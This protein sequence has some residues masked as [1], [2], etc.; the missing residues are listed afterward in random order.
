MIV[1]SKQFSARRRC[2]TLFARLLTL[3]LAVAPP[4]SAG[5]MASLLHNPFPIHSVLSG[6]C[7]G[8]R[9]AAL[10]LEQLSSALSS[11]TSAIGPLYGSLLARRCQLCFTLTMIS[12]PAIGKAFCTRHLRHIVHRQAAGRERRRTAASKPDGAGGSSKS[13]D[14]GCIF[15]TCA[16]QQSQRAVALRRSTSPALTMAGEAV[17]FAT[18]SPVNGKQTAIRLY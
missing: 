7:P 18:S 1:K 17:A 11:R 5:M 6:P 9:A 10:L 12:T 14:F 16:S 13:R 3:R 8:L 15:L 4:S 2:G